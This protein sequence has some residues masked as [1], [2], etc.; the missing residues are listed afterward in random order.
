MKVVFPGLFCL[1]LFAPAAGAV[2]V[3]GSAGAEVRFFPDEARFSGQRDGSISFV[4]E[5]ELYHSWEDGYQLWVFS[6]FARIDSTDSR[7]THFDIREL[8][9]EKATYDWELKVGVAQ[10]FWGV[11]ESVHLVDIINQTDLIENPDGEDKLGQPMVNFSWID[12]WG[13]LDLFLLPYHRKRTFP[14]RTGRLRFG[15]LVDQDDP[16]YESA[17]E[18][19]HTDWAARWSKVLG[20]F[21]LGVSYFS[22]TTREPRLRF[23]TDRLGSLVLQPVYEQI[24]QWGLD[25]QWTREG[26]LLKL[27]AITR[28]GQQGQFIAAAGGFEYTFVGA[29]DTNFD[30][31]LLGEYLFDDRGHDGPSFF[32][33]DFFVGTRLVFN[34]VQ[35]TEVL[36]GSIVDLDTQAQFLSLEFSRRLGSHWKLELQARAFVGVPADDPLA[37]F[38]T[39]DY[40]SASLSWFF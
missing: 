38:R 14:E 26:W 39:D 22:G 33:N 25:A 9:W 3:S 18:E 7:R 28:D 15:V 32:A 8:Y 29:G 13:T 17:A 34:D 10:V 1:L 24:D 11:T 40:V 16:H 30:I 19:W 21:D 2:E 37:A 6:P 5:P 23:G 31:G 12:D 35:G 27:E 36:A 4:Y 20:D